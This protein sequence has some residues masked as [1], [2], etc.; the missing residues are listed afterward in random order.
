MDDL[1]GQ[2]V[3]PVVRAE[4]ALPVTPGPLV[5]VRATGFPSGDSPISWTRFSNTP[6]SSGRVRACREVC[7]PLESVG[8]RAG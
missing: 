1:E 6:D 7:Q 2:Q 5:G 8:Q 3:V 4:R